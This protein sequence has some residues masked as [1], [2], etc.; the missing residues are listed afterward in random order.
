MKDY[1]IIL[2]VRNIVLTKKLLGQC[3]NKQGPTGVKVPSSMTVVMMFNINTINPRYRR[4]LRM[5]MKSSSIMRVKTLCTRMTMVSMSSMIRRKTQIQFVTTL[6]LSTISSKMA[7]MRKLKYTLTMMTRM[8]KNLLSMYERMKITI[9]LKQNMRTKIRSKISI[10]LRCMMITMM[11]R[12]RMKIPITLMMLKCRTKIPKTLRYM[13]T[14]RSMRSSR[15]PKPRKKT[16]ML[17]KILSSEIY[18]CY[19]NHFFFDAIRYELALIVG[20]KLDLSYVT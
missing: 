20:L 9:K 15:I 6:N 14:K 8:F 13:T 4:N 1:L 12:C 2:L 18:K 10:S 17:R 3:S 19:A 11:L 5:K 7:T 16:C